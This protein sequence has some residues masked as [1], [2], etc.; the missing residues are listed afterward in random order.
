MSLGS[1]IY[2]V[3]YSMLGYFAGPAV[4]GSFEALHLP[5]GLVGSGGPLLLLLAGLIVIRRA[6]PHPL[7]RP[8]LRPWQ[9]LR[10]GLVAGLVASFGALWTLDLVV[11]VVGDL[12]WRLPDS[13]PAVF[14]GQVA[15]A[16]SRDATGGLLWLVM[17]LVAG[18][19]WGAVYATWTEPRLPGPDAARGLL[20]AFVPYLVSGGLL[21]PLLV[22]VTDA[23]HVAPLALFAE[24]ARQ[25]FFGLILG[26]AYPV[27]KARH[28]SNRALEPIAAGPSDAHHVPVASVSI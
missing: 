26:L 24:G 3:A 27:L 11:V 16:L 2:I 25:A 1:L 22:Q 12:A 15:Q 4:L 10:V 9:R 28:S 5:I 6:L 17:P 13:L 14:A 19:G 18:V 20:F 8:A 23:S 21:A 7:P